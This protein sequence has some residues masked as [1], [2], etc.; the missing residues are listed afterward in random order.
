MR[1]ASLS[2]GI[3]TLLVA[4]SSAC[5]HQG[6]SDMAP[7]TRVSPSPSFSPGP[8]GQIGSAHAAPTVG[9]V[10]ILL[11]AQS[12]FALD[13]TSPNATTPLR[14]ADIAGTLSQL[15]RVG[16]D[17]N[18]GMTLTNLDSNLCM[19]F[20][21]TATAGAP[22]R[23]APCDGSPQQAWLTTNAN[24][25][26][27]LV[28]VSASLAVANANAA[29][30]ADTP[31]VATAGGA[32]PQTL[33]SFQR[34][35]TGVQPQ[36]FYAGG[37]LGT[38]LRAEAIPG[39]QFFDFDGNT[40]KDPFS[41]MQDAGVNA[42]RVEAFT[43]STLG[44]CPPF[45]EN[46]VLNRE[47]NF[48]LD[49]ACLVTQV[50]SAQI[51]QN[52]NMKVVLTLNMGFDIP[53]AW[54]DYNYIQMLGAIDGEV[55]RQLTPFLQAGIQPDIVLLENE[56]TDG[57]LYNVVLPSGETYARGTGGDANVSALQVQREQCGQL[58]T[59]NMAS[60]PQLAGYYKQEILSAR[61]AIQQA[62]FDNT[63]TRF[64][65]HS[66]GQYIDWKQSVVY[67]TNPNLETLFSNNGTTCNFNQVIP[68]NILNRR[69]ADMLDIM[70]FSS[71]ADP[72]APVDPNSLASLQATFDRLNVTLNLM[73]QVA[74]RYGAY[75]AGPFAG[76]S[77]KQGLG[78][79]YAST[80]VYP[81]QT[82]AQQTH[83]QIYLQ[84]LRTYPWFLG[85]LW[86]E[87]TYTYNNWEGG[88]ATLF[89]RWTAGSQ[90]NLAPTA[91]LQT[92][93]SFA[94]SPQ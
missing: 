89:H 83:T 64:G 4:M 52:H 85:A 75:H 26:Y 81:A 57:I 19:D 39:R 60:Y 40:L 15:W 46:N 65:L 92:W 80:F 18:Q 58:P 42:A 22:L 33:W 88:N 61:R 93:G 72:M 91:T 8:T 20:T 21:A 3:A 35:D 44:A 41:V 6:A 66:H 45:D 25:V 50:T 23:Q 84:T 51:A 82:A 47:L 74:Q 1:Y 14:Q 29:L 11:N 49:D 17:A 31:V 73:N 34:S 2:A 62:G 7:D 90:T 77:V 59:G 86:W 36:W 38:V 32:G 70:G 71:Y 27:Q 10:Y 94:H 79:E 54:Q 67:S 5:G 30:V 76:Q 87:P 12:G 68:A 16:G 9:E 56:G 13:T 43:T 28:G 53:V 78:V 69:A 63:R 48:E 37:C 55:L 24:G